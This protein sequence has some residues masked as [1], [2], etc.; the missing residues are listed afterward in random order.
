M[1]E[2][3]EVS[4]AMRKFQTLAAAAGHAIPGEL[5]LEDPPVEHTTRGDLV[6]SW[7]ARHWAAQVPVAHGT[8][9]LAE[10][11]T[12]HSLNVVDDLTS[13]ADAPG[14]SANLILM[15]P[16]SEERRVGKECRL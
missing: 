1:T 15:G 5:L 14:S 4:E 7:L 13:W 6:E 9:Q 12:G 16:R 3:M 2:P 8:P 10:V 11:A